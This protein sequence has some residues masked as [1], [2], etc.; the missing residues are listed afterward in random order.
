[1]KSMLRIATIATASLA[2]VAGTSAGATASDEG[3]AALVPASASSAPAGSASSLMKPAAVGDAQITSIRVGNG[4]LKQKG[5]NDVSA[6]IQATGYNV[7]SITARVVDSS[8]RAKGWA[9]LR[10]TL[11]GVKIQSNVG[12][13]KRRLVNVK[14]NYYDGQTEAVP[15]TSNFFQLRNYVKVS[16]SSKVKYSGKKK[17][18][19]VRGVKIFNPSNG[20]YKSLRKVKLQYKKGSKWKT[21]KTI[22]LN[23]SGNGSYNFSKKKKYRYRLYSAT[24]STS[25]GLRTNQTSKI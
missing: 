22:K 20:K 7:R 5:L 2:L 10:V 11:N 6:N 9:E 13:G 15:V 3:A 14:I 12:A 25:T 19:R 21:K 16:S 8:G 4:V 17:K 18:V 24:T 23:S 1:M